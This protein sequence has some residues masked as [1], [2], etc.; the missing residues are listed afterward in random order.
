MLKLHLTNVT[1]NMLFVRM[2][3]NTGDEP[4]TKSVHTEEEP[5]IHISIVE[6]FI[7]NPVNETYPCQTHRLKWTMMFTKTF[8]LENFA[9]S[10][11]KSDPLILF[12]KLM[13][14]FSSEHH[15]Y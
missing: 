2:V 14:L 8:D 7:N 6:S 12:C 15:L 3:I 1:P 11:L 5:H 9:K 4:Y 10:L 13:L